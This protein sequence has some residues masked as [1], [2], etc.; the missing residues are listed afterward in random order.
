M[1]FQ[2]YALSLPD[3][4]Y[5]KKPYYHSFLVIQLNFNVNLIIFLVMQPRFP[6]FQLVNFHPLCFS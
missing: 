5:V 1:L 4:N 6:N 2:G 3:F